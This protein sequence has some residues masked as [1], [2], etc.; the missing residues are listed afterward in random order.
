VPVIR[1]HDWLTLDTLPEIDVPEDTWIDWDAKSG[2]FV[3]VGE[4]HPEGITARTPDTG[5]LR[6]GFS[7]PC[8]A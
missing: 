4:R 8:L 7:R 1:T 6:S 3:T 5:L 2:R